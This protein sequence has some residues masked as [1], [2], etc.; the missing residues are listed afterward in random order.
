MY[1]IHVSP[2]APS[3]LGATQL[4]STHY[5]FALF[6][7]H[8]DRVVLALSDP[9]GHIHEI[10]L[11]DRENRTGDIWHIEIDGISD[12]WSYAFRVCGPESTQ[13]KFN[14][15]KYLA[16]PY[17]KNIHSPHTFLSEK[18]SKDYAFSYLKQE[19][20]SWDGDRC[21]HLPKED[22]IIYE[23]HVRSFTLAS[24][25]QVRHPGTFLGIIEKIP[26]LKKLGVT[27]IELLPIFEFDESSNP[28]RNSDFS[29][30]CNYWGYA[31]L[32]FFSPCRRYTYAS[33]PCAPAREF[34][35][36][37]KALHNAGI[38]IILDVVFNHTGMNDTLCSLPWIDRSSYYILDSQGQ[39]CNYSG[40]GNT[41]NTNHVPT[42][43]WILDV[44]RYWVQEM[45]V[46]GFRFDLASVFSR[47][48]KG[49]PISPSP[50]LLAITYDPILANTKIIAE[51]WDAAGLYQVGYFPTLNSR[52]SEW[53][54]SY[55]DTVRAFLNG[56]ENLIGTFASRISGSQDLY[57]QG[58][59]HNS[60]NYICIHDGFT[61]H[62]T[63]AYNNKHNE[64]N[65]ENNQDGTDA[66]YSYNFGEEGATENP[67]ILEL[68]QRQ[69]RNF[70]LTLFLSQGIPMWQSGD[71]YGHTAKGNNNRWAL[72]TPANYFLWDQLEKHPHLMEFVSQAISFRKQH[73]ELFNQGFLTPERISWLNSEAQPIQWQPSHYLAYELKYSRYSLFVAFNSGT[74]PMDIRLPKIREKFL[75]YQ[76]VVNTTIGF[77]PQKILDKVTLDAFTIFVAISYAQ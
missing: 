71:E 34:K 52:W 39:F 61:L 57:A 53:N 38:E 56:N 35:T 63:V 64:D 13:E 24:S 26:Y 68:R 48:P 4:T 47:D 37:V 41:I 74:T 23:M 31:S 22:L 25:S 18:T 76:Q 50:I 19:K 12:Q 32:N 9:Q 14:F 2:G 45:H 1:K 40:C 54:G 55:R 73:K 58:S 28:F 46:D 3:P 16:D 42:T 30:L 49:N 5:R 77:A 8:A 69:M 21:L 6:S 59:P 17:A 60:I 7:S 66:N 72:D 20:F 36:L 67:K 44:L 15:Q 10:A 62:D 65:G 29:S 75:P 43:Q 11:S 27:A 33:D 70:F 51:P